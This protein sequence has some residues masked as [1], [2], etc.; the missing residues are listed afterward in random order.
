MRTIEARL[1]DGTVY[2]KRIPVHGNMH[3]VL[4]EADF[5]GTRTLTYTAGPGGSI[6]GEASQ[7]I[8]NRQNGTPV[9]AVPD[10]GYHFVEWSDGLETPTR[11]DTNVM[12]DISVSARFAINEYNVL[13]EAGSAGGRVIGGGT[14]AHN[15]RVTLTA[16]PND[17]YRF[18]HWRE[19][20]AIVSRTAEY[21]FLAEDGRN[22]TAHF[23]EVGTLLPGVLM[24]L[25]DDQEP[26]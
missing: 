8:E 21:S 22:L 10:I 11:T 1:P 12:A 5:Y 19:N 20:G 15:A 7:S 23:A 16:V 26:E 9:T 24:L 3:V 2:R 18:L 13:V 17:G 4:S 6:E 25:L 14:F